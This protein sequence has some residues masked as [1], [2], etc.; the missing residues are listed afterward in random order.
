MTNKFRINDKKHKFR[1]RYELLDSYTPIKMIFNHPMEDGTRID[2]KTGE[3]VAANYIS[4]IEFSSNDKVL[5]KIT[6]SSQVSKHPY[7]ML[8]L[9]VLYIGVDLTIKWKDN[10]DTEYSVSAQVGV[11]S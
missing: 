8:H 7:F 10:D 6:V 11:N 5:A 4:M 1:A 3:A 2:R 9:P